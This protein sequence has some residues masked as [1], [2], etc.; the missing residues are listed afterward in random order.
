MMPNFGYG[1]KHKLDKIQ[2]SRSQVYSE[3]ARELKRTYPFLKTS[4]QCEVHDY[5]EPAFYCYV[6]HFP[7]G[8]GF[9]NMFLLN[10]IYE[11]L[12]RNPIA[13]RAMS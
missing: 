6:P 12:L 11:K 4:W 2:V 1:K 5:E 7:L 10:K 9:M 8:H 3:I 13:N